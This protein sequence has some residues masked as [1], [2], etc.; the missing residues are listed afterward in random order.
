MHSLFMVKYILLVP[1]I[2]KPEN[3]ISSF[4]HKIFPSKFVA[5][6]LFEFGIY[7]EFVS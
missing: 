6:G 1:K 3:G 2:S 7:L 4:S 5:R